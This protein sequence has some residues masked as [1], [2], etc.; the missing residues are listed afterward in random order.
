[1][2]SRELYNASDAMLVLERR[3]ARDLL[4][5]LNK[6]RDDPLYCRNGHAPKSFTGKA[7]PMMRR[8]NLRRFERWVAAAMAWL[9]LAMAAGSVETA[10]AMRWGSRGNDP[11]PDPG[12]PKGAVAVFNNPARAGYWV[13]PD[14]GYYN[15]EY[16][17]NARA[18]S[19]A[20]ADFATVES[21]SRRLVVRNGVGSSRFSMQK[22]DWVFNVWVPTAWERPTGTAVIDAFFRDSD[23]CPPPEI[24]V[25]TGGNIRWSDVT[26]PKGMVVVD[27]RLEAHGFTLT[28]GTVL[29]GTVV[30][31]AT[32]QPLPA[33]ISVEHPTPKSKGEGKVDY[34]PVA[35]TVADA[36][37]H[38]VLK[39][40]PAGW[41]RLILADDG[42]LPRW[43]Y[44]P[45]TF[46]NLNTDGQPGWHF[47]DHGL[48]R[49][50][51]VSG[52]ALDMSG[53]PLADVEVRVERDVFAP[54]WD[55]WQANKYVTKTGGDGRFRFD[56]VLAG[57]A[58]IRV[59]RDGYCLSGGVRPI[60][61]P[62]K[63]VVL[64]LVQSAQVRVTVDFTGTRRPGTYIVEI[65]P[66]EGGAALP[67]WEQLQRHEVLMHTDHFATDGV[68]VELKPI[69]ANDRIGFNG[70]P[71]GRY[72]LQGWPSPFSSVGRSTAFT[73]I[74]RSKPLVIELKSGETAKITLPV[75]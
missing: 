13:G 18:L 36:R 53:Q 21:K 73:G 42:Y 48:S 22:T 15:A 68:W 9:A 4:K 29:E 64:S 10:F 32:Q 62:A 71:P 2:L 66:A 52:R 46:D 63:D 72:L 74:E 27:E 14:P 61:I 70:V 26:V 3:R 12:W 43:V 45:N 67:T 17:G 1:M 55:Y 25:Y 16:S 28:D 44:N 59:R 41:S 39:N 50:G 51:V 65:Q 38:W 30:D 19:A 40:V 34:T 24:L 6:S 54:D 5:E 57:N 37:G 49:L 31:L 56:Q 20:I 8:A 35:E 60:T 75:K 58:T 23:K 69:E 11:L 47:F 33:R 7:N